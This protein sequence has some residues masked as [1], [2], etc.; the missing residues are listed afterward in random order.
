MYNAK[1]CTHK[2]YMVVNHSAG[3]YSLQCAL[4]I[5]VLISQHPTAW[6]SILYIYEE[7]RRI[8]WGQNMVGEEEGDGY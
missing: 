6:L 1:S 4:V 7:R 2:E 5:T 3:V 8:C